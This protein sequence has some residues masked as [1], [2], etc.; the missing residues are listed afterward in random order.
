MRF[1]KIVTIGLLLSLATTSV[2]QDSLATIVFFRQGRLIGTKPYQVL[3]QE[4]V[5]G[6][7]SP[8]TYFLFSCKPGPVTF[9]AI[10][11][12]EATFKMQVE[13][14]KTYFVECGVGRGLMD[15]IATFR[16][17]TAVEAQLKL[18]KFDKKVSFLLSDAQELSDAKKDTIEALRKMFKRK[19]KSALAL[20]VASGTVALFS[21]G[22]ITINYETKYVNGEYVA[23]PQPPAVV[24]STIVSV[25]GTGAGF[26]KISRYSDKRLTSLIDKYS[27][28]E[29]LPL[30]IKQK[31]KSKYFTKTS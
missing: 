12:S 29:S 15:G 6:L 27:K 31:L 8:D 30:E 28:G 16:Q 20:T 18:S 24:A 21:I 5:I 10:T 3:H 19:K 7:I 25:I 9:K 14:G 26:Y 17:V 11:V 2:A 1:I 22:Y 13:A 4:K 23:L